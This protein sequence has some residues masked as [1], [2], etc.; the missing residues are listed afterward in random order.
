VRCPPRYRTESQCDSPRLQG[1]DPTSR[2]GKHGAIYGAEAGVGDTASFARCAASIR[3][4]PLVDA[5][6][7]LGK[8]I[9]V[10][11]TP[12]VIINGWRYSSPPYDSLAELVG[13]LSRGTR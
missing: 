2:D 9:G 1:D 12:T 4:F 3:S 11:S 7:A 5:G 10:T 6:R 13:S 8:R